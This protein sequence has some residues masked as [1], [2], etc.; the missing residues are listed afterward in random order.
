MIDFH[1]H[2]LPGIDDGASD[3]AEATAMLNMLLDQGAETICFTPHFDAMSDNPDRFL[4]RRTA[5]FNELMNNVTTEVTVRCGAEVA[6]FPG[7]G[8]SEEVK[9]LC[10]EGTDFILVE[11]P[12][13]KWT[14]S[15]AE[16]I[17]ALSL[18]R[19]LK[20]V[21]AHI[22]RYEGCYDQALLEDMLGY[23]EVLLQMN[24]KC[25]I[26]TKTRA[27]ALEKIKHGYIS[28]IGTDAHSIEHRPPNLKEA[29]EI[30]RAE[31]LENKLKEI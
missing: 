13:T 19:E 12:F 31:G 23:G 14:E 21:L 18:D 28:F 20:P 3:A 25:I 26:N 2:I 30:L 29:Y 16:D 24:A 10:L 17:R 7:M 6:Y 5:A 22:E 8:R 9:R 11:M 4:E 15:M 27:D 1:N